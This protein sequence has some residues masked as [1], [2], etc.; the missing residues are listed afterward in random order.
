VLR[1]S[2][3]SVVGEPV[4]VWLRTFDREHGRATTVCEGG[5]SWC[6]RESASV[7]VLYQGATLFEHA[8]ARVR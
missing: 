2:D 3:G 1:G 8:R 5:R 4:Q 6:S 7:L